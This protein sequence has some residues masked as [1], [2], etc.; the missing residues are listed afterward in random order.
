MAEKKK[1]YL[2][3]EEKFF[4]EIYEGKNFETEYAHVEISKKLGKVLYRQVFIYKL[5]EKFIKDNKLK[6]L[7]LGIIEE[8]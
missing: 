7:R 4:S 2:I 3:N 5:D 1:K 8:N 6:L